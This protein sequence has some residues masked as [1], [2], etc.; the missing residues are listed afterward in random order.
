MKKTLQTT[1]TLVVVAAL[2]FSCV[3]TGNEQT[4]ENLKAA[5]TGETNAGAKYAAFSAQATEEGFHNIAKLFAATS[6]AEG[7][8]VQTHNSVLMALD[9]E[10]FHPTADPVEVGTTLE[11]LPMA[12]EGETYEFTVMYPGFISTA[13]AEKATDAV[14]TF[15]WARDAEGTHARLYAE[16]LNILIATGSDETVSSTWY[17]CPIC[18]DVYPCIESVSNCDICQASSA[19][20]QP[21]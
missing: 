9:E 3:N 4:L 6:F 8:H 5:I 13:E 19:A 21:F 20:F 15:V 12:I 11:N 14:R 10:P 1:A 7:L 2:A 17:V 18:G 16:V